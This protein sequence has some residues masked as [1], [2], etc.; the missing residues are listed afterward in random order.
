MISPRRAIVA[1]V[2]IG[3]PAALGQ[4]WL[5]RFNAPQ[6]MP[7]RGLVSLSVAVLIGVVAGIRY[8]QSAVKV[9]A[10]MGFVSGVFLSAVGL[11]ALVTNPAFLGQDPFASAESTLALISSVMA[12]TVVSSWLIA[13]GAALIAFPI[14]I[15]HERKEKE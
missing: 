5:L 9:A 4:V 6:T 1:G 8:K 15:S 10:L 12:G 13:G 2:C 3:L 7:L 14:S 11:Y